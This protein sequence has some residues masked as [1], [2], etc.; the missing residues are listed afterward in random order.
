MNDYKYNTESSF[1]P[2]VHRPAYH[3]HAVIREGR[4]GEAGDQ[5]EGVEGGDKH[6]AQTLVPLVIGVLAAQC[7]DAVHGDGDGHVE[8]VRA[9]KRAD[10]EF[11]RLPLLLL[12]TD[13]KDAP[14]VGQDGHTRADQPR[15]RVG[16]DDV[17]LHGGYLIHHVGA[18]W[19]GAGRNPAV[20][21]E[22]LARAGTQEE[23]EEVVTG[24]RGFRTSGNAGILSGGACTLHG[25][26]SAGRGRGGGAPQ[27]NTRGEG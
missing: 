5:R 17:I 20:H 27:Q 14:G 22:L 16:I 8:D 4:D 1:L 23:K 21:R 13:A 3:P 10:E 19:S 15:Q 11:K 26:A 24:R 7:Y 18:G 12:G 6:L 2:V 9:R 25:R